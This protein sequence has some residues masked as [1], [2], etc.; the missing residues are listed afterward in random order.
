MTAIFFNCGLQISHKMTA[1]LLS[2]FQKVGTRPS[3]SV[4]GPVM[5]LFNYENTP[6]QIY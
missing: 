2:V 4:V 3:M 1:S 6:I 5:V